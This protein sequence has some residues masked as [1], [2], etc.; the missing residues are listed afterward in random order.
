MTSPSTHSQ[1]E[2]SRPAPTLIPPGLLTKLQAQRPTVLDCYL[3]ANLC[4]GAGQGL[5]PTE[6]VGTVLG[7]W[8]SRDITGPA[9]NSLHPSPGAGG[10]EGPLPRQWGP[11]SEPSTQSWTPLQRRDMRIHISVPRQLCS[12]G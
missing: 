3:V 9:E 7:Q 1:R 10:V 12:F 8:G 11:S 2:V 5:I 6:G 4:M